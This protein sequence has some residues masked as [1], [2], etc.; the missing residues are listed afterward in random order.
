MTPWLHGSSSDAVRLSS[1]GD[2]LGGLRLRPGLDRRLSGVSTQTREGALQ[3]HGEKPKPKKRWEEM[4]AFLSRRRRLNG[5]LC[6][7]PPL[8]SLLSSSL[9]Y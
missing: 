8:D 4:A 5:A 2:A 9:L 7:G 6:P 3:K 1:R